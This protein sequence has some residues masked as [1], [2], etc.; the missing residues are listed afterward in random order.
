MTTKGFVA[1]H[2]RDAAFERGLRSFFEYRDLGIRS[3]TDGRVV[4]HVIRA[5][6]GA[7]FAGQ[8]HFHETSFQLV[9]V[10]KGWIEF[11]YEGQGRVRLEAG[12]CVHQPPGIRHRELGH[13]PDVEMLEI[14]MPGEFRTVEVDSVDGSASAGR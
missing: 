14:V 12:S 2:A 5:A 3:A 10:L 1:S 13:S 7:D 8:P 9:Y 11:E 6:Q 4:A